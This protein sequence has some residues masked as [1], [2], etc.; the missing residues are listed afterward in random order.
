MINRN[1]L[2]T[3]ILL[4]LTSFTYANEYT[5]QL[6]DDSIEEFSKKNYDEAL[7]ILDSIL[8]IEPE[9]ETALMY[10][11][12]IEDVLELDQENEILEQEKIAN[13]EVKD[14]TDTAEE[15]NN[16]SEKYNEDF[17]S[18]SLLL[19]WDSN[20][21]NY[22]E[23]GS[24]IILGIPVIDLRLRSEDFDFDISTM[25]IDDIPYSSLFTFSDYKIDLSVGLRY[26]PFDGLNN[27]S[28]F[29]DVKA[30]LYNVD[31]ETI[32]PF[33]GFDS[34]IFLLSPIADNFLT[35]TLWIGGGASIYNFNGEIV[36]NYSTEFKF[37]VQT[38]FF[39]LAWIY[40]S[41]NFDS[42]TDA[43]IDKYGIRIG[44]NF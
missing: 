26:K 22:I 23:Y 20:G 13:L 34:E 35:N 21:N 27:S 33:L 10:K 30:G 17:L 6:L 39:N 19:G 32:V 15:N 18:L 2:F 43:N 36:N 7:E 24:Q 4:L 41:Y 31:D 1:I 14:D 5:D 42:V 37:G 40:K 8:V 25:S 44:F 12:T 38:G 28:G 9:N 29:F 16:I 3:I 11:K